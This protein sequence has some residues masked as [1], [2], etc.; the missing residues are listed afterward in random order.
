MYPNESYYKLFPSLKPN[1]LKL[2]LNIPHLHL[3]VEEYFIVD[4]IVKILGLD[5]ICDGIFGDVDRLYLG[6]I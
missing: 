6:G 2:N 3:S 4:R 5:V 1:F